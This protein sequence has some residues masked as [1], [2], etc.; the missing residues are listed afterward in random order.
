MIRNEY[1]KELRG[2]AD[3]LLP[4]A[5]VED[6][7]LLQQDGSLL[8]GWS[9]RG[10]DMMSA[11]V[12]E[13]EALSARLNQIL[14]LGSGWMIGCDAIRTRAPGYPDVCDFPDAITQLID[15]ERRQ[16][17]LAEGAHFESE[18]FF[19]IAYLPPIEAEEK[20][21]GFLFEGVT[22]SKTNQA[23]RQILDRFGSRIDHFENVFSSLLRVERLKRTTF[24]DESGFAQSYDELLRYLRRCLTGSDHPFVLPDIPCFLTMPLPA[25]TFTEASGLESATDTFT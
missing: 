9:F 7:I 22:R 21:K 17:F 13:M 4:Y 8:A 6:G 5:L 1:R 11:S 15:D 3:L 16:Q 23:A 20:V 14:R 19:T 2:L 12:A 18:Y 10:P 24:T 25:P